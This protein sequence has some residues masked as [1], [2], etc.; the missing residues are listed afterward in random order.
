MEGMRGAT[1]RTAGADSRNYQ[2]LR[3][4]RANFMFKPKPVSRIGA[5]LKGSGQVVRSWLFIFLKPISKVT[6]TYDK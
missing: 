3:K 4:T 2:S 6:K 5:A 1:F